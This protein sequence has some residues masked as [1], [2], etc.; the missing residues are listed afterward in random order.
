M[1]GSLRGLMPGVLRL[2]KS[3]GINRK[4]I[5][6]ALQMLE[7]EGI[8]ESQGAGRRRKIVGPRGGVKLRSLRVEILLSEVTDMK[9]DYMIEI[10]HAL[11]KA[12]HAVSFLSESMADMQMDVARIARKV[13]RSDADAWVVLGGSREVLEWFASQPLPTLA[14]FGRKRG[15]PLAGVGPD[16][17]PAYVATTQ[18]LIGL[19]HRR[20]VLLARPRRCLPEPGASE[21]AF[22]NEL[23]SHGLPVSDYNLPIWEESVEGFHS[24]LESLF[25]LNPPTALIIQEA[26]LFAAAQQFLAQRQIRV[27]QDIS[28]VCTDEDP[29]FA[30]CLPAIS[31][32]RWDSRPVVRRVV[33]WAANVSNGKVDLR[34]T[35]GSAQFIAG[36]TIGPA[37]TLVE[38]E[39]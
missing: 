24:C 25:E 7:V 35:L 22:L 34:Q 28:L 33:R 17:P 1:N 27:P 15:L 37:V 26:T 29:N 18:A 20:I 30:W 19:G 8:I 36:G 23:A 16:K 2:E 12:G 13:K 6:L 5:E 38:G 4:T 10:Q 11:A 9:L 31:H 14:I 32:I 39:K 3:F 21:M